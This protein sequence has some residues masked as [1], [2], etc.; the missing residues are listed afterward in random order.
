[1][2]DFTKS[3][4]IITINLI[5][6]FIFSTESYSSTFSENRELKSMQLGCTALKDPYGENFDWGE[7]KTNEML[8][9]CLLELAK[10]IGSIEGMVGW[11]SQKGFTVSE[12]HRI[13]ING[14]RVVWADWG[15]KNSESMPFDPNWSY[16]RKWYFTGYPY[17][18]SIE[19]VNE[20]PWRAIAQHQTK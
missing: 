2:S 3:L 7:V 19:Y 5:G 16:V 4:Y 6:I 12:N 13:I 1:M 14:R 10:N 8:E 17:A 15:A 18:V 9:D 11:L 20:V